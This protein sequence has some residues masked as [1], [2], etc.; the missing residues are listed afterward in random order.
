MK[1]EMSCTGAC[2][3][4]F[5]LVALV[6]Y[7]TNGDG[8]MTEEWMVYHSNCKHRRQMLLLKIYQFIVIPNF[9]F[10]FKCALDKM[11]ESTR[12]STYVKFLLRPIINYY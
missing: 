7:G 12:G 8:C 4:V 10:I 11:T 5:L 1:G 2:G 9:I 6:G 3:G